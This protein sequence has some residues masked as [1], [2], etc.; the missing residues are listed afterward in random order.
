MKRIAVGGII[1]TV[2]SDSGL[3]DAGDIDMIDV[4]GAGNHGRAGRI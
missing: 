1:T 3:T 2:T 4:S